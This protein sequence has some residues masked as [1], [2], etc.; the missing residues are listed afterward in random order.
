MTDTSLNIDLSSL[1][2]PYTQFFRFIL[3][4][5]ISVVDSLLLNNL[6][7]SFYAAHTPCIVACGD[8]VHMII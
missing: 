6:R 7:V 2:I 1:V 8:E 4:Y 5:I 3:I